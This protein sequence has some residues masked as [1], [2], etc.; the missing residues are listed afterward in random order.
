[1]SLLSSGC[2][3]TDYVCGGEAVLRH[4][5]EMFVLHLCARHEQQCT[6]TSAFCA[7]CASPSQSTV[8]P[9]IATTFPCASK[10]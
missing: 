2:D 4:A 9:L 8:S 10:R 6:S 7:S 3:L 5:T 1:M